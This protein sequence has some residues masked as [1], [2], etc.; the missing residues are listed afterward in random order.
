MARRT[1]STSYT[2]KIDPERTTPKNAFDADTGY[3]GQEFDRQRE[4]AEGSKHPA[5]EV[6]PKASRDGG[7]GLATGELPPEAGRRAW[8]D[9]KSGEVH[10]SGSGAGGG[11][12]SEDYDHSSKGGGGYV[13]SGAN[14]VPPDNTN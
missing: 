10:G 9:P 4:K 5:G 14:G 7:A 8:V 12:N 13:P 6:D 11:N 2:Q 1:L 3:S